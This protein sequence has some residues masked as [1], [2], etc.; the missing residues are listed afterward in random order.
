MQN[1]DVFVVVEHE[2]ENLCEVTLELLG[3]ARVLAPKLSGKVCAIVLMGKIDTPPAWVSTRLAEHGADRVLLVEHRLLDP[4]VTEAYVEALSQLCRRF[5]PALVMAAATEKG[6]DYAPRLAARLGAPFASDC[7]SFKILPD[8]SF[9]ATRPVC[10]DKAHGVVVLQGS[11]PFVVTLRQSVAGVGNGTPKRRI[12]VERVALE[13][14]S[15]A[16][17]VEVIEVVAADPATLDLSEAEII[18]AG[19]RGVG[20]REN[21]GLID[22]LAGVLN[23][24]V[25]ASRVA[26]DLGWTP[27]IRQVGQSGKTVKAKLYVACGI[28][29]ASQHLSGM[30]ECDAVIAINID[31]TAPIMKVAHLSVVGDLNEVIPAIV[32]KIRSRLGRP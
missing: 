18:V 5:G 9:S 25:G 20:S 13:I 24:S 28:S 17:P 19:G 26:V 32:T 31:K 30:Q 15:A 16:V 8:G 23:A 7:I 3:D 29:G 2:G 6:Q 4:Y 1:G 14:D 22:E 11:Q 27:Y 12:D 10:A 21:W